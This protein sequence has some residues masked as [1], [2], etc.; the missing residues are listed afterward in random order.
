MCCRCPDTSSNTSGLRVISMC[1]FL[2]VP[3]VF[4][5]LPLRLYRHAPT[6]PHTQSVTIDM[7]IQRNH[8]SPPLAT[9]IPGF[10]ASFSSFFD[11]ALLVNS[12]AFVKS[13]SNSSSHLST[14]LTI[15]GA[16]GSQYRL[17]NGIA[18]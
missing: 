5:I 4:S 9:L 12:H 10:L 15:P 18:V 14:F 6:K 2:W 8:L 1:F 17:I 11:I 13:R 3:V 16:T 7:L